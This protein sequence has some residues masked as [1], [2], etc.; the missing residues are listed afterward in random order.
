MTSWQSAN[1]G[2]CTRLTYMQRGLEPDA[3]ARDEPEVASRMGVQLSRHCTGSSA[4]P[5]VVRVLLRLALLCLC[6]LC[7]GGSPSTIASPRRTRRRWPTPAPKSK[8]WPYGVGIVPHRP[9][10][11]RM[12]DESAPVCEVP[13]Q[14][15]VQYTGCAGRVNAETCF[16]KC[17]TSYFRDGLPLAPNAP[18]ILTCAIDPDTLQGVF[19]GLSLTC[20][21]AWAPAVQ[22]FCANSHPI[23]RKDSPDEV[24]LQDCQVLCDNTDDC[25]AISWFGGVSTDGWAY[26][27]FMSLE[28]CVVDSTTLSDQGVL[29]YRLSRSE[30]TVTED[31]SG[32]VAASAVSGVVGQCDCSCKPGHY[33]TDC[34]LLE[35][36]GRVPRSRWRAHA[37]GLPDPPQPATRAHHGSLTRTANTNGST[38]W[39]GRPYPLM[40]VRQPGT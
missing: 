11:R 1:A 33:G 26:K 25:Q 10:A 6:Q 22:G 34:G 4:A 18:V 30:C 29:V 5:S 39:P 19:W 40:S 8:R 17:E 37:A 28:H 12:Q 3:C 24:T 9:H 36:H 38:V 15:G 35:A 23:D 7:A 13:T 16:A 21:T 27:C 2:E 32:E 31:C 20:S 14:S